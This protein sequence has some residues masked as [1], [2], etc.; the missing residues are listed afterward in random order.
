MSKNID[1]TD[2]F[3]AK[4]A[5]A[6][7]SNLQ[8]RYRFGEKVYDENDIRQYFYLALVRRR[9]SE[10]R[11]ALECQFSEKYPKRGIDTRI[12]LPTGRVWMEFKF[13]RER[14]RYHLSRT[15]YLGILLSD[16]FRLASLRSGRKYSCYIAD[17]AMIRYFS[18]FNIMELVSGKPF[19]VQSK[20]ND[21]YLGN[22]KVRR[23]SGD[24]I[25][26]KTW[27]LAPNAKV[28]ITPI[29]LKASNL[30]RKPADY[31]YW[32]FLYKIG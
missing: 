6:A 21:F 22:T 7:Y 28:R 2:D 25:R 1:R 4:C 26:K 30:T 23:C 14:P 13:H 29:P 19:T 10:H 15:K 11:I 24:L 9:V 5:D 27:S 12:E 17:S 8:A 32:L 31:P 18:N 20:G 3:L 16:F